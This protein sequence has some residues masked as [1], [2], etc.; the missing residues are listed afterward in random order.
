VPSNRFQG[1]ARTTKRRRRKHRGTQGGSIDRRGGRGPRPRSRE[2]ARARARKNVGKR[3]ETPP[4]WTSA[5]GRAA[6]GAAI[7]FVLLILLFKRPVGVSALLSALML[8]LYIP[9]GHSIDGFI[10][11][12]KLRARQREHEA[13]KAGQ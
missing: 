6:F 4:T 2:E 12:R 1:V 11:R 13:R 9:L 8:L 5:I 7:F 10:Y 3:G